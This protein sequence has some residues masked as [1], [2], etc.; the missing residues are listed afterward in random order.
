MTVIDDL[1]CLYQKRYQLF[2]EFVQRMRYFQELKE[3]D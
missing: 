1:P 2:R 3:D